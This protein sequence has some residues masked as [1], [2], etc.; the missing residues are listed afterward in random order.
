MNLVCGSCS[1]RFDV[2]LHLIIVIFQRTVQLII[3]FIF[4]LIQLVVRLFILIFDYHLI[5]S[6]RCG[7]VLTAVVTR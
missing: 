7:C 4:N 6:I 2:D 3:W 5:L 1:F